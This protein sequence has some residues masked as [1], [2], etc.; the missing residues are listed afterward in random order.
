MV[1]ICRKRKWDGFV[2]AVE[3]I[4]E[5]AKG[6]A[7]EETRLMGSLGSQEQ[8]GALNSTCC[9]DHAS[10]S[11]AASGLLAGESDTG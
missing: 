2:I 1:A 3:R 11:A 5:Y 7:A 6:F 4:R 10:L 9:C 8:L